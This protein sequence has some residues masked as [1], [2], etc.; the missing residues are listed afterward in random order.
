[1][2][3]YVIDANN[4]L[5]PTTG[6][7]EHALEIVDG[8]MVILGEGAEIRASGYMADGISASGRVNLLIDG[9]VGSAQSFGISMSGMLSIGQ[10]GS[11]GGIE[12]VF[13]T[14]GFDQFSSIV[15]NAGTIWGE[16]VGIYGEA[17]HAVIHNSGTITG[18]GGIWVRPANSDTTSLTINNTGVI[19][20]TGG[21][22]IGGT[23]RGTNVVINSGLIKGSVFLG[24]GNDVYDGRGGSII[25]DIHLYS[26]DDVAFGG[27]GSEKFYIQ[28]GTHFIDG[29]EGIDTIRFDRQTFVDLR[30]IYEQK[31]SDTTWDTIRNVENLI[32]SH[33]ADRF[34]GSDDDNTLN[35]VTGNDLLE[36]NDGNDVLIGAAGNDSLS[37]GF[38]TDV[39]VFGGNFSDYAIEKRKDGSFSV[40]DLRS[41]PYDGTD[42]L[43]GIEYAQF[44]DRTIALTATN[45]APTSISLDGT[46]IDVRSK[47]GAL[48]GQLSGVDP[49]GDALGYHLVTNPGSHFRIHG[50]QLIVDKAFASTDTTF[51]IVVRASDP[52][53]ASLDMH[54]IIKVTANGV[55]VLPSDSPS[56][57][58][59]LPETLVLRGGR[60]ADI[61]AGGDGDDHLNGGLGKDK[62]TGGLGDDV[63]A[64]TTRL[65]K[66][67]VDRVVDFRSAEDTIHLASKIFFRLDKGALSQE[68]FHIGAKA[69]DRSD[70]IIFNEKTGAL[71]YDAD[72]SGTKHAAIKFAQLKA[73]TLLQADDFFIV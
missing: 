47:P 2:P 19:E 14:G 31:T 32:G 42:T 7:Y 53:G 34:Y 39:A 50:D 33:W 68:A 16:D 59:P 18:S 49:D 37:G 22:A 41:T 46:V 56:K 29:G 10:S 4:P 63:F 54:F 13:L 62:M 11:V 72:G 8:D 20:G 40:K 73:K 36:G 35:G 24:F 30:Y 65:G 57:S 27:A 9:G 25:G 64:F 69:H 71:S 3:V 17:Y 6:D 5:P 23:Y 38:G 48:V 45:S 52:K 66:T 28:G 70:R 1:M 51:D 15:N 44:A 61:L 67:N 21:Q 43:I 12:G 55:T 60:K 26:G 58:D